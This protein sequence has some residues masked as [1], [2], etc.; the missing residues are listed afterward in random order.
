MAKENFDI[1]TEYIKL[2]KKFKY[3]P[4]FD[5]VNKDFEI[6]L[7]DKNSFIIRSIR[8]KIN[9]KVIFFCRII[10]NIL[11]PSLQ[12]AISGYEAGFFN[13]QEKTK[14]VLLHKKLMIIERNSL[15]LDVECGSDEED[16]KYIIEVNKQWQDFKKELLVMIEKMKDVWKEETKDEEEGYFG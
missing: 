11:Y 6:S 16:V 8:R 13:E 2:R 3:L 14:L 1:E 4:N 10:E 15:L 12:S 7:I 5:L 9:D